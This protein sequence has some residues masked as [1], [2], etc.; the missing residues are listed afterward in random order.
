MPFVLQA[1]NGL[2]ITLS[3]LAYECSTHKPQNLLLLKFVPSQQLL[4]VPELNGV[5]L[6]IFNI[7]DY[8][9]CDL[10]EFVSILL[11]NMLSDSSITFYMHGS[12]LEAKGLEI[13]RSASDTPDKVIL[14]ADWCLL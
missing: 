11:V 13:L 14:L 8:T 12:P 7:N 5:F 6:L 10:D 4:G 1:S 2:I 3:P 9:L